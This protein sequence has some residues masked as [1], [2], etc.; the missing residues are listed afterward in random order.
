MWHST[1]QKY[2]LYIFLN[3]LYYKTH[4][5][6]TNTFAQIQT[7]HVCSKY[8]AFQK[9]MYYISNFHSL[10]FV[11]FVYLYI[12]YRSNRGRKHDLGVRTCFGC[13]FEYVPGVFEHGLGLRKPFARIIW[14]ACRRSAAGACERW[15]SVNKCF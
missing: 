11:Y 1:I 8:Q 3:N 14:R 15:K 7:F 5:K 2:S 13:S 12:F 9:Q 4:N 10:Y 6:Y